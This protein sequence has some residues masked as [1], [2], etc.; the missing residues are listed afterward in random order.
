MIFVGFITFLVLTLTCDM[1]C[2]S[3]QATKYGNEFKLLM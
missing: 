2:V 1:I 3:K